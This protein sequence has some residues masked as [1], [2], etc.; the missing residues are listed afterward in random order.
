MP[1]VKIDYVV[2]FSSED[3]ENPA[4][5]LLQWDIS[6]K[7]WLCP[8]GESSCSVV[9]QLTKSTKISTVNIGA[10]H[11]ALVEVLVGRSETPNDQFQVLVPSSIFLSPI[12]SRKEENVEKV[13]S[14]NSEHFTEATRNQKWDR[15]RVVCSQPYNKHCKFGLSFIQLYEPEG[16]S[17]PPSAATAVPARLLALDAASSDEDEF[18]PG[19]LFATHSQ[20][21]A[22][23]ESQNSDTGAQIRQATSQALKNISE[24]STKLVR[25]PIVK[26]SKKQ[27]DAGDNIED[28]RRN[29]LMYEEEDDQ[30]HAKIDRVLERHKDQTTRE[31]PKRK[32]SSDDID[33][34][35]EEKR[36]LDSNKDKDRPE[37]AK[38][39]K[40]TITPKKAPSPK[41]SAA[42]SSKHRNGD[43]ERR[44][45]PHSERRDKDNGGRRLR[46]GP[47]SAEPHAL[48]RGVVVVLSGYQNP[49]RAHLRTAA[50]AMGA[51]AE[52]DWGPRC[53]HLICAFPN[54]PKLK[55]VRASPRGA[56]AVV[57]KGEWVE[58]CAAQRRLLPWQWYATEPHRYVAPTAQDKDSDRRELE[59][60]CDTDD[61]IEKV[62]NKQKKQKVEK[63][64]SH[65][66]EASPTRVGDTSRESDVEFVKDERIQGNVTVQDSD[67]DVTDEDSD[68]HNTM[69]IDESK[70]LPD[71]FEGYTFLMD[72]SVERSELDAGLLARYVRAYG[73]TLLRASE[74]DEDSDV[75]YVLCGSG[76]VPAATGTPL[77]A[78]WV[79]RCHRRRRLCPTDGYRLAR[80]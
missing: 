66:R 7:K 51:R 23:G 38:H 26:T 75:N 59:S 28:R 64:V 33:N 12:D 11:A 19:Q 47:V 36:S 32:D 20:S 61:E 53:T 27:K 2:S 78:D 79:W 13:R 18:R 4:S 48:M 80:A 39:N 24:T 50:L 58:E 41:A 49:R 69:T 63:P 21:T 29:S 5:N 22:S 57:V 52:R 25:T 71:F 46:A 1:R 31:E 14:F 43:P 72:E 8:R 10:Y 65:Q 70:L 35:S 45:R 62:L 73:G 60:E 3:A 34:K 9:L 68:H 76:A 15:V 67:T 74:L 30:P 55:Q 16:A 77:R 37:T 44:K 17:E 6:K 42:S 56:E 40:K 54:T